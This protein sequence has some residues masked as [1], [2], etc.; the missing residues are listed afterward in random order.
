[1]S[2]MSQLIDSSS[3]LD[4]SHGLSLLDEK[5]H[6]SLLQCLSCWQ[7]QFCYDQVLHTFRR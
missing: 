2:V 7:R 5:Q 6:E 1:M 3:V 4:E